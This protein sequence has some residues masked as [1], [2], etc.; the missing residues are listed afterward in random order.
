[1]SV[2]LGRSNCVYIHLTLVPIVGGSGE[3]KTKP[4]HIP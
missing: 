1:M 2:E 3:I 4:T